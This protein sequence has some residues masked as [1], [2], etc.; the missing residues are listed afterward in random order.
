MILS[1]L[2]KAEHYRHAVSLVA[3]RS[4]P[5]QHA[6]DLSAAL[7][8]FCRPG[9][10]SGLTNTSRDLR[11]EASSHQHV[12]SVYSRCP[13]PWQLAIRSPDAALSAEC[14]A[15]P[16]AARMPE[17]CPAAGT[18]LPGCHFAARLLITG[19]CTDWHSRTSIPRVFRSAL[20]GL[21][22]PPS[23]AVPAQHPCAQRLWHGQPAQGLSPF[24]A[25]GF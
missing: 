22:R 24:H 8:G 14:N 10:C 3:L 12:P 16:A 1:L 4:Q 21:F 7:R 11:A 18:E 23:T 13:S 9:P 19:Q 20:L 2:H 25:F 6:Y 17:L 5:A 15:E